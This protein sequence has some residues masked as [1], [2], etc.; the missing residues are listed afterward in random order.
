MRIFGQYW[1]N[2][3]VSES[4]GEF[5]TFWN[6]WGMDIYHFYGAIFTLLGWPLNTL[7]N[8]PNNL[9]MGHSPPRIVNARISIKQQIER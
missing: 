5:S 2:K 6:F 8:P 3:K 7:S 9:G 1:R 4:E